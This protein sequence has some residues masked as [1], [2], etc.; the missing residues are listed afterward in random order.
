MLEYIDSGA[1]DALAI[2]QSVEASL[3]EEKSW[4]D[5][6]RALARL[7]SLW[8]RRAEQRRQFAT[9]DERMQQDTGLDRSLA[10]YETRKHFWQP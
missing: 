6:L 2:E 5:G 8:W 7:M 3:A 1:G 9:F 4:L 10:W